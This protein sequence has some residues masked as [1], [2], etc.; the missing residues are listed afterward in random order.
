M[1]NLKEV[2]QGRDVDVADETEALRRKAQE[3]L[4][5]ERAEGKSRQ[6]RKE[7]ETLTQSEKVAKELIQPQRTQRK[8]KEKKGKAQKSDCGISTVWTDRAGSRPQGQG[9]VHEGKM[10]SKR[11][12]R[13]TNGSSGSSSSS[14]SRRGEGKSRTQLFRRLQ[15]ATLGRWQMPG[16]KSARVSGHLP[17]SS[18]GLQPRSN[19]SY[20][21]TVLPESGGGQSQPPHGEGVFDLGAWNG[22]L[23][24]AHSLQSDN[25]PAK[26]ART[27]LLTD[28]RG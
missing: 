18:D 14:S 1:S 15:T 24:C 10:R 19:Y 6:R 25:C 3:G 13:S 28:L 5:G 23:I 26:R 7:K 27:Q 2:R 16:W 8:Q 20:G 12:R 17:R 4:L 21:N 22:I 9:P 11:R